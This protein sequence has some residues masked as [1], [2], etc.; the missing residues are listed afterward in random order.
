[1]GQSTWCVGS[2]TQ[3]SALHA[4]ECTLLLL[5]SR[6]LRS[7]QD[8]TN[9]NGDAPVVG[10][11]SGRGCISCPD[12]RLTSARSSLAISARIWR[13]SSRISSSCSSM[14]MDEEEEEDEEEEDMESRNIDSPMK[15]RTSATATAVRCRSP[16][17]VL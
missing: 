1:M 5:M 6:H 12:E 14:D 7:V 10:C 17:A 3:C 9:S 4:L 13:C 2:Q 11:G 8:M 15:P 16:M